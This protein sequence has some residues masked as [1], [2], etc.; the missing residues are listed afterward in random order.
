[1]LIFSM[2]EIMCA[3][4]GEISGKDLA[5]FVVDYAQKTFHI[6]FASVSVLAGFLFYLS[7]HFSFL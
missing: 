6:S 4:L 7:L 5:T 2:S 1:M 3:K